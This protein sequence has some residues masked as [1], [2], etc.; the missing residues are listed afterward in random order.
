[1]WLAMRTK[2][3]YVPIISPIDNN[4]QISDVCVAAHLDTLRPYAAGVVCCLTSGEGW[5]LGYRHWCGMVKATLR[6]RGELDVVIGIEFD[7]TDEVKKLAVQAYSLGA[8]AIMLTTPFGSA[9]S[10]QRMKQHFIDI[11]SAFL[12]DIWIY[13]ERAISDNNMT[14]DTLLEVSSL[15]RV[16]AIKDS[17]ETDTLWRVSDQF[18]KLGVTLYRG[19]ESQ[20]MIGGI[21][22]RNLVSLANLEPELCHQATH[23]KF[24]IQLKVEIEHKIA[25]YQLQKDDWYRYIKQILTARGIIKTDKLINEHEVEWNVKS[26]I[27]F[28]V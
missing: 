12:G 17:S 23:A 11:H 28:S 2:S 20:L 10:Q 13:H 1:M 8:T 27:S 7:S 22:D 16:R 24:D 15:P 14:V 21:E 26:E 4:N 18:E 19:M 9:V 25:E 5:R 3:I 6:H